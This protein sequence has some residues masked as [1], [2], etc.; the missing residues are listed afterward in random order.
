MT[1]ASWRDSIEIWGITETYYSEWLNASS[2]S[3]NNWQRELLLSHDQLKI[4]RQG[5]LL[6]NDF[7]ED[8]DEKL[9]YALEQIG[10]NHFID[11]NLTG[12]GVKIG[13]IDGGFL[14]APDNHNLSHF[15]SNKQI[16][17][18]KDF[19]T[20]K[21]KA[22]GG[23][24]NLDDQHGTEVWEMLGGHSVKKKIRGYLL[25]GKN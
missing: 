1:A 22:Y 10:A 24:S 13:I 9:S 11:N 23:N 19:I 7:T 4:Q 25:P 8:S 15:F 20:P 14:G 12:K 2:V 16:A 3:I 6:T 5:N 18:Y 21:L 17:A